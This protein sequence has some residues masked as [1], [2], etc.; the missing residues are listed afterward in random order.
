MPGRPITAQQARIYMENRESGQQAAA[1]KAGISE[2]SARRLDRRGGALAPPPVRDWRTREDPLEEVW[3][4]EIVPLLRREGGELLGTTVLEHLQRLHPGKI[5]DGLLRTVQRRLSQWRLKHGKPPETM[6]PQTEEPGRIGYSDFTHAEELSVTIGGVAFPHLL[7]HFRLGFSGW[8][9]VRVVEG[10]ESFSALAEGLREAVVELGGVPKVHRTDSLS[11]AFRN[12]SQDAAH[13]QTVAYQQFCG[14]LGMQSTR[15]NLGVSHENGA[16]E[17]PH[18]H[19]KRALDQALRL[20]GSRDFA[21]VTAYRAWIA[22]QVAAR[23]ANLDQ[24]RVQADRAALRPLPEVVPGREI[25]ARSLVVRVSSTSSISVNKVSY[26]V[27]DRLIGRQLTVQIFDDRLECYHQGERVEI[28]PRLQRQ[29]DA[30]QWVVDYHRVIESLA[31]KPGAFPRL[32]YRDQIHPG[33]VWKLTWEALL[34]ALG[35]R[36]AARIYLGILLLAHRA[37]CEQELTVM[38]TEH[39]AA[40]QLPDLD[41]LRARFLPR[42]AGDP[43]PIIVLIPDSSTYDR[44]LSTIWSQA[45]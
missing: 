20:R 31:R 16:V 17:S 32:A 34:L 10:G 40:D 9:H 26:L 22:E 35:E 18:G 44:L 43:P 28:L 21:E 15:N 2:R 6:F 5:P 29:G 36:Q 19:V 25:A 8:N 3:E 14:D 45:S 24:D 11:A 13:D 7:Y 33:P 27:S 1:A 41:A 37:A 12:V 39:R 30:R 38:L 42:G 4:S 23:R